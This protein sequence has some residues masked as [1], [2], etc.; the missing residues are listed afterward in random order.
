[1]GGFVATDVE[2]RR[3]KRPRHVVTDTF[4][5]SMEIPA[6]E[7]LHDRQH[8]NRNVACRHALLE[9]VTQRISIER[10][11]KEE[12]GDNDVLSTRESE[13]GVSLLP[14]LASRLPC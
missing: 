13:R 2:D 6:R 10:A 7:L 5:D 1:M 3:R 12:P 11:R 4:H 14:L 8:H 9:L